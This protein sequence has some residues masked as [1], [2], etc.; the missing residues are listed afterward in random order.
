M[1][2]AQCH[3][4]MDGWQDRVSKIRVAG[5]AGR[6]PGLVPAR[7]VSDAS[8]VGDEGLNTMADRAGDWLAQA[9]R[10]LEQARDSQRAE[11]HEWACFAARQAAEKAVKALHLSHGQDVWGHVIARLL[12]E[13]P[14][15][16]PPDL[17]EKARVLDNFY[18]ATRYAN[19]HPEGAPYE[20]YGILQSEDAITH[21]R[22][23]LDFVRAEMA[24]P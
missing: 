6:W 22:E 7:P 15:V 13:L 24:R 1:A 14:F 3:R 21:A 2:P 18:V 23:V 12:R 16:C 11:R 19:G 17:I 9:E 20:H 8:A 10:D 4:S 5:I